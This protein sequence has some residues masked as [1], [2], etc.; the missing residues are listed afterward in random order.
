MLHKIHRGEELAA[1]A[2]YVVVGFGAS[3]YPNNFT[4]HTYNEVVFPSLP[5]GVEQCRMC[6][7]EDNTAWHEP[8]DRSHPTEQGRPVQAWRAVCGSCHD[9]DAV[10][11]HIQ[12]QT[13]PS[14]AE[15]CPVC[16][17]SDAEFPVELFHK[18]R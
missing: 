17:A 11:A 10:T 18:A 7:G 6:H 2:N 8:S 15:A 1:G 9:E 16:H 13:A 14:G 4:P 5:G 3:A 12:S